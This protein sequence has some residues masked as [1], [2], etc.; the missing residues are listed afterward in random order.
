VFSIAVTESSQVGEARRRCVEAACELGFDAIA[1]GRVAI[2]ATELATNL[3]RHGGGGEVVFGADTAGGLDLLALDRGP[4]M[5]D[6]L[7][8]LVDGQSS[9]GT[10]GIG[11]GAVRRQARG[12]AI[13][14]RPGRGT[15]VLAHLT[16]AMPPPPAVP[17]P[18]PPW[19][20]VCIP[21]RGEIACGDAWAAVADERARVF[22]LADGLGHGPEA[23]A[24]A[25]EALLRF[26]QAPMRPPALILEAIHLAL[27]PTR[28]A[29][30][31]IARIE[32]GRVI[33]AGIGNIA[34][35]VLAD[36]TIKRMVSHNGTAGHQ[37]RRIR[38]FEYPCPPGATLVMHSDGLASSWWPLRHPELPSLHPMLAAA[39]L[40]RDHARGH[41]D[42]C[43]LVAEAGT[44]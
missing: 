4:G 22:L 1:T 5:A 14:S 44:T 6:P 8:C 27:R 9:A 38:E 24:A 16:A 3:I 28:G 36:G 10:A 39:L 37:A 33:F 21:R 13:H 15:A 42:C 30:V 40:Y 20:A 23:A 26:R 41:D 32:A 2:V 12:F 18:F 11:L 34:G 29:A 17:P 7:L 35:A 19:G 43:V 25:A 31:A